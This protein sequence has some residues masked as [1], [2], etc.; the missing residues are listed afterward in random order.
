MSLCCPCVSMSLLP[1]WKQVPPDV[2]PLV[3]SSC[4]SSQAALNGRVQAPVVLA[5]AGSAGGVRCG[6]GTKLTLYLTFPPP[7][8]SPCLSWQAALDGRVQAPVLSA[9]LG[10][11]VQVECDVEGGHALCSAN[12]G[13]GSA[14]SISLHHDTQVRPR[15]SNIGIGCMYLL[16]MCYTVLCQCGAGLRCLHL[17]PPRHA[18][19]TVPGSEGALKSVRVHTL[20]VFCELLMGDKVSSASI[21]LP[22]KRRCSLGWVGLGFIGMAHSRSGDTDRKAWKA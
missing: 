21:S 18:G 22:S 8:S 11:A 13:L 9:V 20:S 10:R 6:G 14:A 15:L 12:V 16:S 4:V 5:G 7:V 3:P 1:S 19:K 17:P 2:L